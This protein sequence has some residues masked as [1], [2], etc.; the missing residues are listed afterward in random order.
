MS[1]SKRA[2][3]DT[4]PRKHVRKAVQAQLADIVDAIDEGASISA[5]YR[6]LRSDGVEVGAG[7]SSF[8]YAL[9][10][11]ESEIEAIR[12]S[13]RA[14]DAGNATEHSSGPSKFTDN[15]HSSRWN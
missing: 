10:A 11:L 6:T 7:L 5:I 15:E 12:D 9:K 2:T 14:T 13:K 4:G 3:D 1:F 8:R